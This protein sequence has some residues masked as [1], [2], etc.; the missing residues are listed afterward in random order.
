[1]P[2]ASRK[3]AEFSG[4]FPGVIGRITEA[5]AVYYHEHWGLD[6]SFE[7]QV[8]RELSEF[9]DAF[10][11]DRDGI[12]VATIEGQFAGSVVIDGRPASAEGARLRWFIVVPPCQGAGLGMALLARAMEFCR[13]KRYRKVHLWTFEGLHAARALYERVGFRL[14]EAHAVCQ[15]GR[16]LTEQKFELNLEDLCH[17]QK[18]PGG[19]PGRFHPSDA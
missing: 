1:M 13:G 9:I 8:G 18:I 2:K 12:W 16:K 17:G 5:H 3:D 4:Y 11:K 7:A 14:C 19:L 6:A 15:W 10:R